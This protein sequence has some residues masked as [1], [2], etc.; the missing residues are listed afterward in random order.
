MGDKGVLILL[1]PRWGSTFKGTCRNW[2]QGMRAGAWRGQCDALCSVKPLL[3]VEEG[4]K[5][6]KR[7]HFLFFLLL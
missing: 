2:K 1:V 5:S 6:S 7:I 4:V 3:L